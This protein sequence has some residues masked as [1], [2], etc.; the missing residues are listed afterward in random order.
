MLLPFFWCVWCGGL[1]NDFLFRLIS[2]ASE[3]LNF[4][5]AMGP[6]NMGMSTKNANHRP[7]EN[8]SKLE[9][10]FGESE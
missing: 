2:I 6:K 5:H 10:N 8:N 3:S 4:H 7:A 9:A 1:Q